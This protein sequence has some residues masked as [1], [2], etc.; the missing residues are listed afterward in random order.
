MDSR[1]PPGSVGRMSKPTA[2][3]ASLSAGTTLEYDRT[4]S[5][6]PESDYGWTLSVYI[7]GAGEAS[8]TGIVLASGVYAVSIAASATAA[9]PP[10]PH[11][12]L[13]RLVEIAPG[14]RVF[15]L[16][17]GPLAV[18]ANLASARAG[19][20]LSFEARLLAAIEARLLGR[21]TTD[22]ETLQVEGTAIAR[23]PFDQLE[24]LREKYRAIVDAQEAPESTIGSIEIGFG[25]IT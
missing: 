3:P 14:T 19:S 12:Y 25:R 16:E 5:N 17:T 13:E 11:Q 20:A 21:A 7:A 18:T 4:V 24:R 15:D 2:M 6:P 23:I 1:G 9:L 8:Q 22:Q 10:G